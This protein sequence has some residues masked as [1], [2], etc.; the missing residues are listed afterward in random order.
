MLSVSTHKNRNAGE[1]AAGV[2][3]AGVPAA[4]IFLF[5]ISLAVFAFSLAKILMG[6]SRWLGDRHTVE[7]S[8]YTSFRIQFSLVKIV[9]RVK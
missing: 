6:I 1:A 2:P 7:S 8:R 5:N 3:V 4:G 9:T